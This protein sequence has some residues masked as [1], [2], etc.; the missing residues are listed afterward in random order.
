MLGE[1]AGRQLGEAEWGAEGGEGGSRPASGSCM[2]PPPSVKA[3][4]LWE[5]GPL[6][7]GGRGSP[8]STQAGP[9]WEARGL[10]E[11]FLGGRDKTLQE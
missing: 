8:S 10:Q 4:G 9:S 3:G 7:G 6:W 2:P 1:V 5:T 11:G